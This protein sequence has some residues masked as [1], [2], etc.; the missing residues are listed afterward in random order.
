MNIDFHAHVYPEDYLKRLEASTGMSG[1][2]LTTRA[3]SGS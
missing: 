3:K 1:S 2:K